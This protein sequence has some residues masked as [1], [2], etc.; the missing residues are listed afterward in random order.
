M[1]NDRLDFHMMKKKKWKY[2]QRFFWNFDFKLHVA[3]L[4]VFSIIGDLYFIVQWL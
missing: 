3:F 4:F 2:I 1:I